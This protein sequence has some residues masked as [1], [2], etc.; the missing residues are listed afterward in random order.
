MKKTLF[1]VVQHIALT[2][3]EELGLQERL[4]DELDEDVDVTHSRLRAAQKKLNVVMKQ[5][6]GC[7]MTL[8]T[9][10]LMAILMVVIIICFKLAKLFL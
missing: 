2:I 10:G 5:S 6:G 3:H 7:K 8:I 1:F 4:L 9:I